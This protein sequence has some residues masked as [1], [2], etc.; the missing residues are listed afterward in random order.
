[1]VEANS[2]LLTTMDGGLIVEAKKHPNLDVDKPWMLKPIWAW[3][4]EDLAPKTRGQTSQ[5]QM[6]ECIGLLRR[7]AVQL[8]VTSH[9]KEE[10]V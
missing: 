9:N 5:A 7:S 6:L 3:L 10:N 2:F 1:M 4:F 8:K